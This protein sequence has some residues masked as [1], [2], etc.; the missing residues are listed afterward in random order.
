M[1]IYL[2]AAAPLIVSGLRLALIFTIH[3]IIF[4]EMYA[5]SEGI[6]RRILDWGEAFQMEP[7][8]ATVL[9]VLI[10]T[11]ALNESMQLIEA[12]VRTRL[13]LGAGA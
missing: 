1:H 5:S 2:P 7:L 11:M 3:G 4:A 12:R 13:S 6:G 8:L 9:L 10:V